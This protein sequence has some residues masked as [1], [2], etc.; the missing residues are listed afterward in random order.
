MKRAIVFAGGGSKGAYQVGAWKAL[1]E[2]GEQFDIATGTSIGSIN[3]GFYVQNDFLAAYRMW[4]EI[5]ASTIME[6][7][8][9]FEKSFSAIY[10]QK[11]QLVPFVKKFISSKGADVTP[12]HN[13]L[14]GYF[15]PK[16][17]AESDIDYALM[18]TAFPKM[19]PRTVLKNEIVEKGDEGWQWIAASA[20]A[21]PVF[22]TMEVDG[23]KYVD[24]G[25]YDNIPVAAAFRLGAEKVTVIDLK[26]WSTHEG[27][28][29]HPLVTCIRPTR[30]LGTF[31]NFERHV[32]DRSIRLGYNDT[33]KAYRR[34]F[35]CLFTYIPGSYDEE[36]LQALASSF[37]DAL[38]FTEARHE[39]FDSVHMRRV[40]S[41][42]GCCSLLH[43]RSYAGRDDSISLF[44]SGLEIL[45]ELLGFRD[46][47]VYRLDEL[48]PRLTESLALGNTADDFTSDG[49]NHEIIRF[50]RSEY[51]NSVSDL[52]ILDDDD[53]PALISRA[54]AAALLRNAEQAS[55]LC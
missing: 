35:G 2:L 34:Y 43:D 45:M 5:T 27:Y 25:Y 41:V 49:G 37:I 32:I 24:G 33:M 38:T 42:P 44:F 36:K 39:Y 21:W 31:L 22:P 48:L 8:I 1:N 6:N 52:K 30:D 54:L 12:F 4:Q 18:T 51:D 19:E 23:E 53:R 50:I 20:A 9:N 46:E 17:F 11:E 29:H 13:C 7:G 3:A 47:P 28:A 55:A 40:N 10:S 26:P 15:N 16:K 14:K